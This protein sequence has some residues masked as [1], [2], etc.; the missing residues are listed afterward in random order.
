MWHCIQR[1]DDIRHVTDRYIIHYM[2][3]TYITYIYSRAKQKGNIFTS[4]QILSFDFLIYYKKIL[5]VIVTSS[6][7]RSPLGVIIGTFSSRIKS[8]VSIILPVKQMCVKIQK[9]I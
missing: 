5:T 4:E 9:I 7:I 2:Q 6:A 8:S 3:I 1:A